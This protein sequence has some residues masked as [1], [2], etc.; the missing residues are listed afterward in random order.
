M[1]H[2][3]FF[4]SYEPLSQRWLYIQV[5]HNEGYPK[6]NAENFKIWTFIC[7]T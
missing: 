6:R 1:E 5:L 2:K 7:I 3:I 4:L